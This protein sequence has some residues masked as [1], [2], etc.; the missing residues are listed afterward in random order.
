M[1]SRHIPD[2]LNTFTYSG[3]PDKHNPRI[4]RVVERPPGRFR[5]LLR[6]GPR[7]VILRGTPT[8][9]AELRNLLGAPK[10]G[11]RDK[12]LSDV[13]IPPNSPHSGDTMTLR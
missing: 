7:V 8:P 2:T 10:L 11:L 12:P 13:I 1:I 5:R 3:K 6:L 4:D 9:G